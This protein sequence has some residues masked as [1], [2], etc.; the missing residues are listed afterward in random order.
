MK[1]K[2][3]LQK[4]KIPFALVPDWKSMWRWWS[5][6]IA[7]LGLALPDLLQLISS[8]I[9]ALPNIDSGAKE[10]IRMACLAGVILLRP[11]RQA[12]L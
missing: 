2:A 3:L 1:F 7:L 11:V 5:V 12:S 10:Y 6:R 9:D 8:S 4:L